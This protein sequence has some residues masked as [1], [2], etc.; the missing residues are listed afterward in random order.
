MVNI[1]CICIVAYLPWVNI[2]L[3]QLSAVESDYWIKPITFNTL[4]QYFQFIFSPSNNVLGIILILMVVVLIFGFIK[5]N[6]FENFKINYSMMLV[7]T[8]F[9]VMLVG[10]I[11]SLLIRPIFVSRYLLPLFGGFYLGIAILV[12]NVKSN[13][14]LFSILL[15]IL[16]GI[17]IAGV[18]GFINETNVDFNISN[19]NQN[20][21]DSVNEEGV[22]IIFNDGLSFIRY[23]PYLDKA[24]IVVGDINSSIANYSNSKIIV[25][26]KHHDLDNSNFE[27]IG[28]INQ[29]TV[30]IIKK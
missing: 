17:S 30:Y 11:L 1:C 18:I 20:L 6:K 2:L 25:F 15:V 24:I 12:D 9:V 13:K 23:S 26:D 10:I 28:V 29:D 5:N 19:D 16:V 4:L 27:K 3:S 7:A 22:V 8:I 14:K 21:L